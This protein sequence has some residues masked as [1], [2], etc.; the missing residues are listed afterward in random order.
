MG[1][2]EDWDLSYD[3]IN[4]LLTNN[5]SL[6]SFVMGYTAEVKCKNMYFTDHPNITNI[7]KPDDHNRT[8]KGDLII[9]YK[10]HRFAV[11]VKSIQTVS[12]LERKRSGLVEPF[13]QCDASDKR[14]VIFQDGSK[15]ETTALI[16]GEFDIVAVNIHA[17]TGQWDFVF[18][19]NEDLPTMEGATRGAAKNFTTY[20]QQ[21]LIRTSISIEP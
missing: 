11:E 13:Y 3:E 1:F 6:R 2:L 10:G 16:V 4:E 12:M 9:T 20:Q 7:Y 15:V 19:K 21:H 18:A 8:E 5:P 17:F 14:A